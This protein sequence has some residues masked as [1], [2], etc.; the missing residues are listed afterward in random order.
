MRY[1]TIVSIA[2]FGEV[3]KSLSTIALSGVPGR[4]RTARKSDTSGWIS[5]RLNWRWDPET[6]A[7]N[8]EPFEHLVPSPD[9]AW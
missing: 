8:G 1:R 9:L 7:R 3:V 2:R 5:H 4:V 6:I